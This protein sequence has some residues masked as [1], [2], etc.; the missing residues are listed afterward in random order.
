MLAVFRAKETHGQQV[1]MGIAFPATV[2]GNTSDGNIICTGKT[3]YKL[4]E[5]DNDSSIY[6]I[7]VA[8]P[9]AVF[10]EIG[11][12]DEYYILKDGIAKVTVSDVNGKIITGDLVTPSK[13]PG[14]GVKATRNGPVIGTAMEDQ[15]EANSSIYVSLNI[16]YTTAFTE[17][18]TNLIEIL[19]EGLRAPVLTPLSALRYILAAAVVISAFILGFV[20][21]GRLARSGV[22]AIAR[23]PLATGRIEFTVVLHILITIAIFLVGLGLAYII[24]VL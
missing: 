10:G 15:G 17:S 7:V 16:H 3:G 21:F 5:S 11:N 20:Y 8:S 1:G 22:E 18:R 13:T 12:T 14:I 4:C 6:G 24:L 19:Q 23:N 9:S 2:A